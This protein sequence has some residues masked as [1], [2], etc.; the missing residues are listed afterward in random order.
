MRRDWAGG[1]GCGRL[2]EG[3]NLLLLQGSCMIDC[4]HACHLRAL[5]HVHNALLR[6]S[7][8]ALTCYAVCG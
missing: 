1:S 3:N 6:A 5:L 8:T 4:W 2:G 7:H